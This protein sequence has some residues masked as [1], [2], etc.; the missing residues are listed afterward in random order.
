M[1]GS[2][3]GR[4]ADRQTDRQDRENFL[5]FWKRIQFSK[6]AATFHA[7]FTFLEELFYFYG[8][9][10]AWEGF[11]FKKKKKKGQTKNILMTFLCSKLF[12]YPQTTLLLNKVCKMEYNL[13]YL[14]R[15]LV[16]WE[17][18]FFL[19]ISKTCVMR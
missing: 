3:F 2:C 7:L 6:A 12:F 4:H 1:L 9:I 5:L 19:R 16:F 15:H 8:L 13:I 10:L 11:A 17:N 14:S 18:S